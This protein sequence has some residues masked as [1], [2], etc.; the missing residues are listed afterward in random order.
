MPTR[1]RV[2][3]NAPLGQKIKTTG[4]A[5][6]FIT[7]QSRALLQENGRAYDESASGG[8]YISEDPIGLAGG[9]N[10]YAYVNGNPIKYR[11]PLGL[12]LETWE[13]GDTPVTGPL[14]GASIGVG[15]QIGSTTVGW[16][17]SS[18]GAQWGQTTQIG[19]GFGVEVCYNRPP[20]ESCRSTPPVPR[21]PDN[22]TGGFGRH[23]GVQINSNGSWC[24]IP[25]PSYSPLGGG[26]G[27]D[28]NP[29]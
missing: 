18:S 3:Q 24:I 22:V 27:W 13:P 11:D 9:M 12:V 6:F 15:G 29:R 26:F 21:P 14:P 8:L 10:L 20:K 2:G 23:L 16:N 7:P 17:T 1:T 19:A 4:R 5:V 25:G 28:L